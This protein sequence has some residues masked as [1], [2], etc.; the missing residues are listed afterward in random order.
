[1]KF[2]TFFVNNKTETKVT[3]STQDK[4][5]RFVEYKLLEKLLSFIYLFIY[6]LDTYYFVVQKEKAMEF[7]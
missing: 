3:K 2:E 7:I 6:L 4:N 5:K 1:M